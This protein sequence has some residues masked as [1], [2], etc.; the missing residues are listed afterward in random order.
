MI[1]MKI[2]SKTIESLRIRPDRGQKLKEKSFEISMISKEMVSEADLVN[3]LIDNYLDLI[4]VKNG[5]LLIKGK[6]E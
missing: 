6:G 5:E 4:S 2:R 3:F 1:K